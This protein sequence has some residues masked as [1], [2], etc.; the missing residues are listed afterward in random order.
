MYHHRK[1]ISFTF[2]KITI[3]Y[4]L[5]LENPIKT[6]YY[7]LIL[8]HM[9]STQVFSITLLSIELF[10]LFKLFPFS[11]FFFF[12]FFFHAFFLFAH[13]F[14]SYSLRV[15]CFYALCNVNIFYTF[16]I[17]IKRYQLRH[18]SDFLHSPL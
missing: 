10:F 13:L 5:F 14:F 1:R 2:L 15:V 4:V 8:T 7:L 3:I 11:L 12:F 18:K 9:F 17:Y 16:S 6:Y